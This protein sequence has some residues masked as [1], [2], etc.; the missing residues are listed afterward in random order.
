MGRLKYGAIGKSPTADRP[1]DKTITQDVEHANSLQ[2]A[3]A[4]KRGISSES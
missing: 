1:T 2:I 3:A 4:G